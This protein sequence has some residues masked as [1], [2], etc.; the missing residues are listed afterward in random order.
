VEEQPGCRG[1]AVLANEDLGVTMVASYWENT[2]A[3][4]SSERA[5]QTSRKE[6]TEL[7]NGL[8]TVENYDVPIFMR[9]SHPQTGAGVRVT[10][11]EDDSG[12]L[13][14]MIDAFRDTA[15][16]GLAKMPGLCSAQLMVDR[17]TG[18]CLV[19]S[20]YKNHEALA[21]SRA[22]IARLR[23][24]TLAKTRASVRTVQELS[25][26]FSS[27]RE[28]GT[29]SLTARE[30]ELWNAHDRERWQ[31]LFD[32]Q[33]FEVHA[34]AGMQR[35]GPDALDALWNTWNDAFPDNQLATVGMY[36]DERGGVLEG[37]FT[38][39]QSGTL[40]SAAGEI[41]ATGRS[42]DVRFCQVHRVQGGKIIDI[43]LYFD[44]M[45]LLTQLGQLS[46]TS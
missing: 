2:E 6:A 1:L 28:G 16:P 4:Y 30:A 15:L 7:A 36:G 32:Q 24:D 12:D 5:V 46:G 14:A 25:L 45:D 23:A 9:L 39:T 31:A 29:N 18:R 26:V 13:D 34:P 10:T 37:R 40:R 42:V 33:A 8:V 11:I 44:Q 43:H 27:V 41:P 17:A 20:A 38:G 35:S 3:M 19:I 22:S 21:A